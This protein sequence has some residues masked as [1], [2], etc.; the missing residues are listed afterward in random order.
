VIT[1]YRVA[2]Q[3]SV[4]VLGTDKVGAVL[5][6]LVGAGANDL[7]GIAFGIAEPAPL[8]DGARRNAIADARRKAEL[9][10]TAAG[11]QLGRVLHVDEAGGGGPPVPIAYARMEAAAAP[12]ASGQLELSASVT[13]T[14]AMAP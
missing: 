7:G 2:N 13:V 1:G 14:F 12:I 10:A 8:L 11:V 4:E 9:Y 6:A 3:V 5:D